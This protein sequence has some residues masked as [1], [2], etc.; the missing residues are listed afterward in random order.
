M[1]GD[2]AGH[3]LQLALAGELLA[4]AVLLLLDL[5][6]APGARHV[7]TGAAAAATAAA[8]AAATWHRKLWRLRPRRYLRRPR[9]RH[10]RACAPAFARRSRH[11]GSA[12]R[13]SA[14]PPRLA[15]APAPA[16][17][18]SPH[19]EGGR[20]R[21]VVPDCHVTPA[22][23]SRA[24]RQRPRAAAPAA[25]RLRRSLRSSLGAPHC[26]TACPHQRAARPRRP[27]PA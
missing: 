1:T 2:G 14:L 26:L 27:S 12:A 4:H 17:A 21:L 18:R 6:A 8:A 25:G 10:S 19:S 15:P 16:R 22:R 11:H 23:R 9:P 24:R 3:A 5:G 7:S 20:S 13:P